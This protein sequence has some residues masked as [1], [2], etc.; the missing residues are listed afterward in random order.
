[1]SQN[2]KDNL[3]V[4]KILMFACLAIQSVMGTI[5]TWTPIAVLPPSIIVFWGFA[6]IGLW[7]LTLIMIVAYVVNLQALVDLK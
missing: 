5:F 2:I 6:S 3:R 7:V 4:S 1:M